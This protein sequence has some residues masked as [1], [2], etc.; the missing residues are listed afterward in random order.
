VVVVD[1][2]SGPFATAWNETLARSARGS[3]PSASAV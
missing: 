3:R 1:A 2:S